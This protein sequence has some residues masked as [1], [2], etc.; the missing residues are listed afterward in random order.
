MPTYR[1]E[2]VRRGWSVTADHGDGAATFLATHAT[3]KAAKTMA[4]LLAGWNGRVV[5]VRA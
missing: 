5:E 4:R 3:R 2:K 1:I